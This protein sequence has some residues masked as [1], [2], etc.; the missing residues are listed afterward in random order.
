M[1]TD[2]QAARED[3]AFL[4]GLVDDDPRAGLWFF[5][6]IYVA[7]G[8]TIC[9]HLLLEYVLEAPFFGIGLVVLYG[10][11]SVL[12]HW[13]GRRIRVHD[14]RATQGVRSRAAGAVFLAAILAHLVMLG[15]FVIVAWRLETWEL[16]QL[17]PVVLFATQGVVWSVVHA[18][19]PQTW[20]LLETSGWFLGAL[21]LGAV[22]T[23][24]AFS[25]VLAVLVVVLMIIP[26]VHMMRA[27]R[28]LG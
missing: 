20:T 5:G 12:F 7:I 22:I 23:T 25:P 16:V 15:V 9:V 4:R 19:G 14:R 10:A 6:A 1:S 17:A 13:I 11:A 18:L 21:A 24:D 8:A 28:K 26:G 27:A 2:I 3:L